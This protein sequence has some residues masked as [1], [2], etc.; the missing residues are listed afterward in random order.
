MI[1][2]ESI[3]IFNQS[4]AELKTRLEILELQKEGFLP[5]M[6]TRD[7]IRVAKLIEKRLYEI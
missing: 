1:D 5:D 7:I 6:N 4:L 2:R 3:K